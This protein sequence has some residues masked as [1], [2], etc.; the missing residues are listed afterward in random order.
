MTK[1][2]VFSYKQYEDLRESY[3][4]LLADNSKLIQDNRRLRK[5]NIGL[6]LEI[7]VLR[8]YGERKND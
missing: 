6:E 1:P 8:A 5:E 2:I 7:A 3:K 4:E